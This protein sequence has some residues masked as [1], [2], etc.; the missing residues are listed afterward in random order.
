MESLTWSISRNPEADAARMLML[1][2]PLGLANAQLAIEQQ[3]IPALDAS[4]QGLAAAIGGTPRTN[5]GVQQIEVPVLLGDLRQLDDGLIGYWN[6]SGTTTAFDNFYTEAVTVDTNGIQPPPYDNILLTF[7][8]AAPTPVT[9]LF[10]PR[11]K[12]HATTGILPVKAIDLPSQYYLP[13]LQNMQATFLTAP[14][15]SGPQGGLA[16]PLPG[17]ET[18]EWSWIQASDA[19]WAAPVT[20]V[21]VNALAGL[22]PLPQ[23][24]LEGWLRTNVENS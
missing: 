10:D 6:R 22:Q 8:D 2:N 12:V 19:S 11:G 13:A 21:P 7:G 9:V 20:P 1:G 16:L 3:G 14:V 5:G 24:I 4:F 15:L 17:N 18:G 23:Q